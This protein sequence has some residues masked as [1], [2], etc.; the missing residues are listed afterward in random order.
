MFSRFGLA[1]LYS[2]SQPINKQSQDGSKNQYHGLSLI[3]TG[4]VNLRDCGLANYKHLR[5]CKT[6]GFL[7]V[8][9]K[10]RRNPKNLN[11][12]A[13]AAESSSS[14]FQPQVSATNSSGILCRLFSFFFFFFS[15][16]PLP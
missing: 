16:F 3:S 5:Q 4:R 10:H 12:A 1:L 9:I 8:Y 15:R 7:K 11:L 6:K 14:P 2:I 13:V